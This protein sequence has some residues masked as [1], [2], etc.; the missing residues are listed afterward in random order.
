MGRAVALAEEASRRGW[1]VFKRVGEVIEVLFPRL[2][3]PQEM[4]WIREQS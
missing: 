1:I 3:T 2:I 4:E